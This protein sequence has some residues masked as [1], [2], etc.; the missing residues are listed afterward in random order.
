MRF[1]ISHAAVENWGV[2]SH[3]TKVGNGPLLMCY[4]RSRIFELCRIFGAVL[5]AFDFYFVDVTRTS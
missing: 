3:A 5:F 1:C 2:H 4:K